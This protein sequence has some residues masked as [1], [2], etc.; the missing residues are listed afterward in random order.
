MNLILITNMED[1]VVAFAPKLTQRALGNGTLNKVPL[2]LHKP[3]FT[4]QIYAEIAQTRSYGFYRFRLLSSSFMKE[5][6]V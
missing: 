5:R 6:W 3:V 1:F 2:R 4:K